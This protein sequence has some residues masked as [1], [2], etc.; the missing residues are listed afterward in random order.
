L[1]DSKISAL[2]AATSLAD[3]DMIPL[4]TAAAAT[5][6]I[7]GASL[8]ASFG[9]SLIS[10]SVL[11][12]PAANFDL[13]SIPQTFNHLRVVYLGATSDAGAVVV[14]STYNGD[15]S[16]IYDY[17]TVGSSSGTASG[18]ETLASAFGRWGAIPPSTA[19]SN[20][21]FGVI[22]IPFYTGTA[23][24]KMSNFSGGYSTGT[25]TGN[26][27]I[28][29]FWNRWRSTA[30]ITRITIALSAGNW[31]TGSSCSLYGIT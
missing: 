1:A 16:A 11:G 24:H 25:A 7:T 19:T 28:D 12:A 9:L 22:D 27:H 31:I 18:S 8:R 3:T 6:K 23:F 5:K 30:A 20:G 13:T 2:T 17:Q 4:A 26:L 21:G 15:S 14:R 10:T 29:Y